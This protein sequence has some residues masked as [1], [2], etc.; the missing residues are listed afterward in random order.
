MPNLDLLETMFVKK[1]LGG[2][3]DLTRGFGRELQ[4]RAGNAE[5]PVTQLNASHF[6][7]V[8]VFNTI[9]EMKN[10]NT[11]FMGNYKCATVKQTG[12]LYFYN[13]TEWVTPSSLSYQVANFNDLASVPADV[14]VCVVTEPIRGGVFVYDETKKT[15]NNGGTIVNGWVRQ[16]DGEVNI[17]WFGAVGN[18]V[19]DDTEAIQKAV[20]FEPAIWFPKGT[21]FITDTIQLKTNSHLRGTLGSYIKMSEDKAMI[22]MGNFSV[23]QTLGFEGQPDRLNQVGTLVD[24]GA[25]QAEVT[26]SKVIG[27]TFKLIGGKAWGITNVA[28]TGNI[29]ANNSFNAC[30]VGVDIGLNGNGSVVSGNVFDNCGSGVRTTEASAEVVGN[31][32]VNCNYNVEIVAGNSSNNAHV[33]FSGCTMLNSK[34]YAIYGN[35]PTSNN[36]KFDGC[37]IKGRIFLASCNGFNF[38]NCDLTGSEITFSSSDDNYFV[39]CVTDNI[40]V[41]NDYQGILTRNFFVNSIT[42]KPFDSQT[43]GDLDGGYLELTQTGADF[44]ITQ[45]VAKII[46][47][48]TTSQALPYHPN[49]TKDKFFTDSNG[50]IDL[51]K[52]VSI[53]NKKYVRAEVQLWL[54]DSASNTRDNIDVYL[55]RVLADDEDVN[56]NI[57]VT[58]VE[59]ICS[60]TGVTFGSQALYSFSG[61]IPRGKYKLVSKA[62]G[63][64]SGK[65]FLKDGTTSGSGTG[66]APFKVRFWGI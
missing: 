3:E 60:K 30:V 58:R 56:Q 36:Y 16:F 4:D 59:A 52:V 43:E 40:V 37:I 27:C 6:Q 10:V 28:N 9:E 41:N 5:T 18:G 2:A 29:C 54:N 1:E 17:K 38:S 8:L 53:T 64:L 39:N 42:K 25:S 62:S 61:N 31:T 47:F 24:G 35:N 49:Y 48:D 22:K 11:E 21:Y 44:D 19:D 51:T 23:V 32:F 20:D 14:K 55:Y 12:Q 7:G 46:T 34:T 26:N 66:K 45:N 65:K 63:S 50:L 57:D 13:G 33:V 15:I